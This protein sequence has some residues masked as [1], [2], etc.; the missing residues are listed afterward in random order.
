M[1]IRPESTYAQNAAFAMGRA[2]DDAVI[3][4]IY[5]TAY[6]GEDGSTTVP[7]PSGQ[8]IAQDGT[9]SSI[10]LAKVIAARTLF[11]KASVDPDEQR[12]I[13]Y[14]PSVAGAYLNITEVKSTD[15]N[16]N[17]VLVNGRVDTHMGFKFIESN[18]L[19]LVTTGTY[20]AAYA[21]CKNGVGIMVAEDVKTR[22]SERDDKSYSVQVFVSMDIGATRIED[23]KVAEI[24]CLA[25]D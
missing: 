15:Y 8:K 4:A 18:R 25:S 13:V 14:S 1:L 5:G 21:Y 17:R 7:L 23:E 2:M 11:G 9:P 12:F 22:I 6:S 20:R 19:P 24:P 3:E 10:T 16:T